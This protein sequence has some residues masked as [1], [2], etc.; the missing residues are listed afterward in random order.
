M[1]YTKYSA[2]AGV[3]IA[4]AAIFSIATSAAAQNAPKVD[5]SKK[6]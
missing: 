3:L 1:K 6:P 4:G 2:L 5:F